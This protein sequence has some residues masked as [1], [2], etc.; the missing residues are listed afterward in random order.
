M[1]HAGRLDHPGEERVRAAQTAPQPRGLGGRLV[2][3]LVQ[4]SVFE[5]VLWY[6]YRCTSIMW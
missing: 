5:Q 4:G 6:F 3:Q 1:G 2:P